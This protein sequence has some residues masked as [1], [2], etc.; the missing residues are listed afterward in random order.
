MKHAATFET[1]RGVRRRATVLM[2]ALGSIATLP[3][4]ARADDCA[5]IR[6]AALAT[7]KAPSGV[8]QFL[9][10]GT[11]PER[12]VSV[13]KGDMVYI[14]LAP[15]MWRSMPRSEVQADAASGDTEK[16]YRQCR[17]MG[18]DLVDGQPTTVYEF[19]AEFA[20]RPPAAARVWIGRDGL[21]YKQELPGR[22]V[23]RYEFKDVKAPQ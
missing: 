11:R 3:V 4:V 2:L 14:A 5:L 19:S 21:I 12:L 10:V 1:P 17:A 9:T 16:A 13:S 23:M 15:G 20:G 18:P 8:R 6:Q 22:G 7:L